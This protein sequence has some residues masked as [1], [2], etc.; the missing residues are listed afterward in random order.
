M[1]PVVAQSPTTLLV[2]NAVPS[3][4]VMAQIETPNPADVGTSNPAGLVQFRAKGQSWIEVTDAAG[5]VQFRKTLEAGEVA[6]ASGAM[7]L[8]V[9]VGRANLTTVQVRGQNFDLSAL[10]KDNVARFEVR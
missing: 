5:T 4:A 2:Q 8:K 7:P 10:T 1:P 6:G 3:A 9:V